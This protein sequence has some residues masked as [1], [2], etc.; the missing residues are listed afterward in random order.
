[1]KYDYKMKLLWMVLE[2]LEIFLYLAC[3]F[4]QIFMFRRQIIK[5]AQNWGW[6]HYLFIAEMDSAQKNT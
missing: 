6:K 5:I 4:D 3:N 2:I 1:M